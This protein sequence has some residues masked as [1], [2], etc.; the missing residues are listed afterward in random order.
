[1]IKSFHS[2]WRN[3]GVGIDFEFALQP[4]IVSINDVDQSHMEEDDD[5]KD[6]IA[7]LLFIRFQDHFK[8]SFISVSSWLS[9][10]AIPFSGVF[11]Q[12]KFYWFPQFENSLRSNSTVKKSPFA[13][14]W[15]DI[16]SKKKW[17]APLLESCILL[18]S[19][20]SLCTVVLLSQVLFF[21]FLFFPFSLFHLLR[22]ALK[23][24]M[25]GSG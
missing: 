10:L 9:F 13:V 1:M 7:R 19:I 12:Q 4:S 25:E 2:A 6:N 17:V 22:L 3:R 14:S 16:L 21:S 11:S 23:R 5:N 20:S 24:E 15:L 8:P 18:I